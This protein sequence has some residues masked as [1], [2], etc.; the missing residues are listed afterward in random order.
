MSAILEADKLT[1]VF[2]RGIFNKVHNVAVNDI[3]LRIDE[4]NPSITVI[5]GESGSGKNDIG[6]DAA[7]IYAPYQRL[8]PISG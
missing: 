4:A 1:R 8:D 2:S 7:R 5:A 6:V 3:S